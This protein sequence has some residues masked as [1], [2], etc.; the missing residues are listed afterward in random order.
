MQFREDV[1]SPK[2]LF[3]RARVDDIELEIKVEDTLKKMWR[4]RPKVINC[5]HLLTQD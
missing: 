5:Y 4:D 3:Y 2:E 1:L